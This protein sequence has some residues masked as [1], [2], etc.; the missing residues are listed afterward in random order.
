M[1]NE[2]IDLKEAVD[3]ELSYQQDACYEA[4]AYSICNMG[5]GC[6]TGM[7]YAEAIG[8]IEMCGRKDRCLDV[9]F[10]KASKQFIEFLDSGRGK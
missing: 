2:I 10:E 9:V 7:C 3:I 8:D 6:T 4:R 1:D 5:V